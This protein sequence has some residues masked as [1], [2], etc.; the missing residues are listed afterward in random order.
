MWKMKGR[1]DQMALVT[2][3]GIRLPDLKQ[4]AAGRALEEPEGVTRVYLPLSY[5]APTKGVLHRYSSVLA[6]QVIAAP[7]QPEGVP[8]VATVSGV[9]SSEKVFSHPVYGE[10]VCLVMDCM[11]ARRPAP[12]APRNPETLTP[13]QI[14]EAARVCAVTDELDGGY[15]ADKLAAFAGDTDILVADGVELQPYSSAARAVLNESVEQVY[16]GLQLAAKAVGAAS[17]H[18]AVGP[19][20]GNLRRALSQRLGGENRLFVT[21]SKYPADIFAPSPRGKRIRRM[22]VQA[23]L[24]LYRAAVYGEPHLAGVVTVA[25]DAVATPRN[26]RVP[27]GIP[28]E[29]LWRHCGLSAEP[30]VYLFGD[31]MTGRQVENGDIPVLPGD[32]CLLALAD[33][34]RPEPEVCVGCGQCIQSCHRGLAPVSLI[35]AARRGGKTAALR[36]HPE[37]C[38]GCGACSAVCPAGIELS[39]QIRALKKEAEDHE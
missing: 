6:G 19:L 15:V 7:L 36:W 30:T 29:A 17:C 3:H 32:T 16:K 38:D 33:P 23:L 22:G 13:E 25:G 27:F 28:A 34:P 4:P 21:R 37:E 10:R 8:V 39:A 9:Y 14:R 35:R 1:V 12:D 11:D 2:R 24:A 5:S 18:L 20:P 31:L 26:L